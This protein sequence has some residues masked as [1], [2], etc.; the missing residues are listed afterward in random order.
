MHPSIRTILTA[1]AATLALLTVVP[2]GAQGGPKGGNGG[3]WIL[4]APRPLALVAEAVSTHDYE[5]AVEVHRD[6]NTEEDLVFRLDSAL[7]DQVGSVQ[8][9]SVQ[10]LL[11]MD[12]LFLTLPRALIQ[13]ARASRVDT[14]DV[15]VTNGTVANGLILSV[16]P[17][18]VDLYVY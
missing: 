9:D 2:A 10:T 6:L 1:L 8:V 15:V 12:G 7:A 14:I 13:R 11:Q 5:N 17:S 18:R 3:V 4:P 16:S